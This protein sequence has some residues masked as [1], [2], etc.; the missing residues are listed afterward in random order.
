MSFLPSDS[1]T[2]HRLSSS[3]RKFDDYIPALDDEE[4][5]DDNDL[6]FVSVRMKKDES[7]NVIASSQHFTAVTT[8]PSPRGGAK[9]AQSSC[10]SYTSSSRQL[11]PTGNR[12]QFFVRMT[13][14]NTVVVSA[15]IDDTIHSLHERIRV[16]TR[17]PVSEQRLIY[18][19]RQLQA[20][21]TLHDYAI[22]N[23]TTMQLVCR[24]RSTDRPITWR[25]M[26]DMITVACRLYKGDPMPP[27]MK[28]ITAL[29]S[30]FLDILQ[31]QKDEH[32]VSISHLQIFLSSS[33][34]AALVM[35]YMSRNLTYK[36]WANESIALLLTTSKA[37]FAKPLLSQCALIVL[38]FCKLLKTISSDDP[39]Y[40]LCRC[41]L[42]SFLDSIG[43]SHGEEGKGLIVV[44][45]IFPF[46]C[47]LADSLSKDLVCSNEPDAIFGPSSDDVRD[48]GLFLRPFRNLIME[49]VGHV[50]LIPIHQSEK[51]FNHSRY[52]VEIAHLYT[53]FSTLLRKMDS[54]LLKMG[55]FLPTKGMPESLI[56]ADWSQYLAILKEL[57][58]I[59]KLYNGAE[60]RFWAVLI[61]R[62]T[63]V[64]RL[65]VKC[66][67][68]SDDNQW[69]LDRK[70]VTDFESRRHLTMLLF[71]E[72]KE[73]YEELHEMLIDR[74]HL[75]AESFEYVQR[76]DPDSLH[77][78]LFMEFKNEEATGPG[79]LREWFYLVCQA[80]FNQENAL[81]VASPHDRRRFYP[82]PASN[83][84]SMHLDYLNFSGRVIA[85]A[86]MHKVQVGVV[87]DRIFFLQLAGLPISLPDI[88]DA[89]PDLYNSCKQILEMDSEF[90][91]SDAL[92]LTF[93]R[94][95]EE[96][97]SRSMVEL[98]PGG[99]NMIVNSKNREEYVNLLVQ[100]RFVTSIS[101]QV[102]H[103]SQGFAD[104]LSN[105]RLQK[106]FF[107][108]L[109]L[110]DLDRMLYGSETA[111][112]VEDWK[113]HTD[114]NG[115]RATDPQ[116]IK[117]WK[118]VGEMSAE[119]RKILLF[120]WTSVKYLPVEGFRGLA[121]R[122][123]IYRTVEP[124]DRLPSSHTCFYRLC[125]PPYP[126]IAVMRNRLNIITQEHVGCSFV[127]L[128]RK[129]KQEARKNQSVSASLD[130]IFIVIVRVMFETNC[131]DSAWAS[132]LLDFEPSKEELGAGKACL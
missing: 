30:Q 4:Q 54:C 70:D 130:F 60:E 24:M 132:A 101:G 18:R 81:F 26:D 23:D 36:K 122:L 43:I 100:N 123:S 8:T 104:I 15:N 75:L 80:L 20:E 127:F 11:G 31:K 48:F 124:I 58:G 92:G 115:Y 121:S 27:N 96:L 3:K 113:A 34:P 76:A 116:I 107:R 5:N 38:E 42:G 21:N 17:M 10:S 51:G 57:N 99:K 41:T 90:I 50:G 111:I 49:Q 35:L 39:L 45:E 65:I 118:V 12:I 61:T 78:G 1:P 69:L 105:L 16:M 84:N 59:S 73:D 55:E 126:T 103:F 129:I 95:V 86:L 25:L 131:L 110:E 14:G 22:E 87:F 85:L 64:C 109:D 67:K 74:S 91:D 83:V 106:L 40:L 6:D 37:T 28:S 7:N 117:F 114:Y 77:G 125:V 52:E 44:R 53:I 82:N 108:S 93:V 63:S 9:S 112:S 88:K 56:P 2:C 47:E 68:R 46:V 79:V 94:E 32:D 102:S 120:F 89:D 97:G 19:G 62:K 13:E 98:C 66:A 72:V 33:V 71:P 119:R 29:M 128:Y